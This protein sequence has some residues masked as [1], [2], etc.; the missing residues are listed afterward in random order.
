MEKITLDTQCHDEEMVVSSC[1]G[2]VVVTVN[3][4]DDRHKAFRCVET[5]ASLEMSV[6]QVCDL[7]NALSTAVADIEDKENG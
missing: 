2:L 7:I 6:G 3:I 4:L 5:V 1:N